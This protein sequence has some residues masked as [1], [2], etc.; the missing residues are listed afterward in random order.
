MGK[1]HKPKPMKVFDRY[2]PSPR[3]WKEWSRL[4]QMDRDMMS[5]QE[6]D[7]HL[8]RIHE[9]YVLPED[10]IKLFGQY[11]EYTQTRKVTFAFPVPGGTTSVMWYARFGD[12]HIGIAPDGDLAR[13]CLSYQADDFVTKPFPA[14]YNAS[15]PLLQHWWNRSIRTRMLSVRDGRVFIRDRCT[16]ILVPKWLC[17]TA[18][19]L[20]RS[21]VTR[22]RPF[23]FGDAFSNDVERLCWLTE[24]SVHRKFETP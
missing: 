6:R 14:L 20:R 9:Q 5:V 1:K 11:G 3:S 16:S 21:G 15:L 19:L 7:E 12:V 18:D 24:I 4:I 8:F 2:E 17:G 23:T 22:V 13:L 10:L